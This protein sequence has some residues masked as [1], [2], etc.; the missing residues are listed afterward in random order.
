MKIIGTESEIKSFKILMEGLIS[1]YKIA[2][3]TEAVDCVSCGDDCTVCILD[4]SNCD[5][6]DESRVEFIIEEKWINY[7]EGIW[8]WMQ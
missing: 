8:K 1:A 4:P 6:I 7:S 3:D 5:Q 2:V